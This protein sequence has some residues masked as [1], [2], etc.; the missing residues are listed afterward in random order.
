M[1][2]TL[3]SMFIVSV[4][5]LASCGG[6][7]EGKKL[8]LNDYQKHRVAALKELANIPNDQLEP[9]QLEVKTTAEQRAGVRRISIRQFQIVSDCPPEHGGFS[10]GPGSPESTIT[11]LASDLADHFLS[12]ASLR[13]VRIDSLGVSIA[14][15]PDTVK[16]EK[17][18]IYPHNILYT[19]YVKTDASDEELE[20]IRVQAEKESPVFHLVTEKQNVVQ[21]IDYA[22]TP[23]EE[24][25]VGPYAPGLRQYLQ[26][27]SRAIKWTEQQLAKDTILWQK[28]SEP[29]QYD[30]LHVEIDPLSGARK[31]HIR[32]HNF[33]HDNLPILGGNDL[34]PASYEHILGTLTSCITHI[35]EIQAAKN[36]FA[37]DSL[38]VTV[39]ATYDLRAG[40][41]GFEDVPVSPYDIKYTW[42]IRTPRSYDDAVNL[43]DLV[44]SVCPIYNLYINEQSIEGRIVREN[45]D[46]YR[47]HPQSRSQYSY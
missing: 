14:T 32:W 21:E 2:K 9:Y 38:W 40:R 1:K 31:V 13:G 5:V 8:S 6:F 42:H 22:Q 3:T 18:I 25:L 16:L 26:Y 39:N 12:V 44:E 17:P 10:L 47:L 29:E 4:I 15:R 30:R 28:L 33:I 36:N 24:Q 7:E 45:P 20:S 35:T 34:G 23:A 41:E 37:I 46:E 19:I 11:A 43:R 27:K